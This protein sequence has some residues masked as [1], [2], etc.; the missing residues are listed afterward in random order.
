MIV[1][2]RRNEIAP[3]LAIAVAEAILQSHQKAPRANGET[4]LASI[5]GI[6]DRNTAKFR[7]VQRT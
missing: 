4:W 5:P 7:A 1:S 6:I 2:P 3:S